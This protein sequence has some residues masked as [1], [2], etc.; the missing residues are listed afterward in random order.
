MKAKNRKGQVA[1]EFLLAFAA[2]LVLVGVIVA[3]ARALEAGERGMQDA[4]ADRVLAEES[5]S[6][7]GAGC[8]A[9]RASADLPLAHVVSGERVSVGGSSGMIITGCGGVE[10]EPV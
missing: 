9:G 3:G 7:M 4:A 6:A 8:W 1:A 5:S 10:G 2:F